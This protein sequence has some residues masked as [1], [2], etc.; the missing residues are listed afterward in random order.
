M[1]RNI[2]GYIS[3]TGLTV[4][5]C[6]LIYASYD[7]PSLFS[8]ARE[9]FSWLAA[10]V[11]CLSGLYFILSSRFWNDKYVKLKDLEL[12]NLI[13]KKEIENQELTDKLTSNNHESKN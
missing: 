7:S 9:L 5:L 2:T 11:V 10:F 3:L 1:I 13:L 8:R 12:D 4:M 6:L